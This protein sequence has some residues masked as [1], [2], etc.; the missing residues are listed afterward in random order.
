M[1]RITQ[2][3]LYP[4]KGMRGETRDKLQI[5]HTV[6]VYLDRA[7]AFS[8]KPG[9]PNAWAPKTAF[10]VGMNSPKMV[11][12]DHK[13]VESME[14]LKSLVKDELQLN[15][16]PDYIT[17]WGTYNLTDTEGPTVSLLNMAT[18]RLFETFLHQNGHLPL[19]KPLNAE[20]FRM[21][22]QVDDWEPFAELGLPD[23][24]PGTRQITI[25]GLRF[26]VHDACERCRATQANPKT[27]EEDLATLK[28]LR[29][30]MEL[31]Y[32]GY[33]SPHRGH[34]I[35]MGLILKPLD[36]GQLKL[37]DELLT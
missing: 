4:V 32:P 18:F 7:T 25:G 33:Q 3:T 17:T 27:G 35:V 37:G 30:F 28:L 15:D 11:S 21:N 6:G 19:Q 34:N 36:S 9:Q 1:P 16:E 8:R 22:V 2:L 12:I 10:Y 13:W 14:G 29:T 24:Y 26:E 23:A 20:R 31:H 5:N